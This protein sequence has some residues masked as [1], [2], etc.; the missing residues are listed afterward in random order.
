VIRHLLLTEEHRLLLF[1]ELDDAPGPTRV[2]LPTGATNGCSP[3]RLSFLHF[4]LVLICWF[5]L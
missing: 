2:S 1:D 3:N 5:S 4:R